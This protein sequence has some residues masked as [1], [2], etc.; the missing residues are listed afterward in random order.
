M[1][2]FFFIFIV[3]LLIIG[4]VCNQIISKE[5][6]MGKNPTVDLKLENQYLKPITI[7]DKKIIFLYY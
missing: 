3:I 6:M 1:E 4:L 2:T 7:R 5:N